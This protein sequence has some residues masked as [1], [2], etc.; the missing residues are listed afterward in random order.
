MIAAKTQTDKQS[1]NAEVRRWIEYFFP[2]RLHIHLHFQRQNQNLALSCEKGGASFCVDPHSLLSGKKS[3]L[4]SSCKD[5]KQSPRT[6]ELQHP[7]AACES[8]STVD[9]PKLNLTLHMYIFPKNRSEVQLE[10]FCWICS[11]NNK[12]WQNCAGEKVAEN[13]YVLRVLI[14]M[15]LIDHAWRETVEHIQSNTLACQFSGFR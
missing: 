6:T 13:T 3:H 9:P 8:N 12:L 15:V 10:I 7:F 11:M 1:W 5:R 2:G 4:D 14:P